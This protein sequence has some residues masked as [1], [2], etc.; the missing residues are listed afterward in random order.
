M[1]KYSVH[2]T[3]DA[4]KDLEDIYE[5]IAEQSGFP[6]RAWAFVGRLHKQ[7]LTLET[8][9]FRGHARDDLM[10]D[11]RITPLE[12]NTVAAFMIDEQKS[13]V[14]VLNVFYGG[15][16]YEAIMAQSSERP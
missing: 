6:E 14:L 13:F 16:D 8:A 10:K 9:P 1:K 2:F 4:I 3:P 12:K 11:L 7:C 15:R 5:Y